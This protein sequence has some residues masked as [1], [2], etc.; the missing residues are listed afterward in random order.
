MNFRLV[1][2]FWPGA[3]LCAIG[4]CFESPP[5]LDNTTRP[6]RAHP[7]Y[8]SMAV[9]HGG[10]TPQ[11]T[12]PPNDG[13][14][15]QTLGPQEFLEH[16]T[17]EREISG[18]FIGFTVTG[19]HR[20]WIRESDVPG[21]MD[22]LDSTQPCQSVNKAISSFLGMSNSTTGR[23]AAFL[24]EGF[25]SEIERTGYGGYPPELES[26]RALRRDRPAIVEWWEK[27][28]STR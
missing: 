3:L 2:H 26:T 23:E 8:Q 13:F 5:D 25:R 19:T 10:E 9:D 18:E 28:L 24:I 7:V 21:L 12:P 1:F 16:L 6:S 22:Q 11:L 27:R 15:F 4:G 20:G 17:L 14:D